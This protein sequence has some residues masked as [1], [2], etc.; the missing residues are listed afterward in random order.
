MSPRVSVVIPTC[1][2]A[3]LLPQAVE[4]VL[5]QSFQDFEILVVDDGAAGCGAL[6]ESC[7]D[8]RIA[9]IRH[10]HRRGG[11]AARNTG[12]AGARAEYV[13]FL[14]DDDEW[15]PDKLARQVELMD[16]N[17]PAVGACYTGCLVVEKSSGRIQRQITPRRNGK[18][19]PAILGDNFIGGT[20]SVMAKKSCLERVGCFDESLP[21]FQDYDLWIRLAREF[22]F[23]SI[24][25]PLLRYSVHD[26]QVWTNLEALTR[27]LELMLRKYGADAG[28][29]KKSSLYF[30]SFGRRYCERNQPAAARKAFWRAAQL[31]P[32]RMKNYLYLGASFLGAGNL[33]RM[34]RAKARI[35]ARA[36]KNSLMPNLSRHA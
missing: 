29:R 19:Y 25:E 31:D 14:D 1:D 16:R 24:A 9:Y 12:I 8:A 35:R 30:Q 17:L 2:R 7:A 20:S 22:E 36:K 32:G 27:G 5:S 6:V 28:F 33:E 13:A 18:L 11:A 23:A 4:S 10:P 21:S 3:A 26:R 34:S 15:L